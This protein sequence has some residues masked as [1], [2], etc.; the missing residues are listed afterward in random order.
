E[1]ESFLP[2]S[3][4]LPLTPFSGK[5]RVLTLTRPT[6]ETTET[7]IQSLADVQ[8]TLLNQWQVLADLGNPS[9]SLTE[10]E[11][12]VK[13]KI[14]RAFEQYQQV[15]TAAEISRSQAQQ[16]VDVLTL[17]TSHYQIEQSRLNSLLTQ[18]QE[19]ETRL[20]ELG[21]QKAALET[22]T[23]ELLASIR[24][25]I[26]KAEADLAKAKT[27]LL[28]PFADVDDNLQT[29]PQPWQE[30]AHQEAQTAQ[31]FQ[32]QA[33]IQG[34]EAQRYQAI[35][36]NINP[37]RW[38]VVKTERDR[39]GRTKQ[40]WG[41]G[42]NQ[43]LLKQQTQAKWQG[44]VAANNSTILNQ[45]SQ[46]SQI[47]QDNLTDYGEFLAARK[48]SLS[49]EGATL[50]DVTT[51]IQFLQQQ[52][53]EQEKVVNQ[54]TQLTAIAESRRLENQQLVDWHN[55][56]IKRWE[57][58][59]TKRKRSGKTKKVYGWVHYPEHILPRNQAQQLANQ[60]A[61]EKQV[62]QQLTAQAQQQLDGLNEQIRQLQ[63]RQRDW[64]VLKQGIEYEIAASELR[65]QGQIDLLTLHEPVQQQKLETLNLQIQQTETELNQLLQEQLPSQQ[66][67]TDKTQQRLQDT[68]SQW[69][70]SQQAA[71]T[72]QDERQNQLELSGFLLPYRERLTAIRTQ[73]QRLEDERV[74]VQLMIQE[75]TSQLSQTPSESLSQQLSEWQNYLETLNQRLA[76]VTIQQ[77][78]LA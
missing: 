8:E 52:A 61:Q 29:N 53:A 63:E 60:A 76:W 71:A 68:Q 16:W 11:A 39:S 7:A 23:Q 70:T 22:D 47:Q 27:K 77:E 15:I 55:S 18:Q 40:V 59:G 9:L 67:L 5:G 24:H 32:A 4:D 69:Q 51:I 57:V 3:S 49:F 6:S 42:T 25:E 14:N 66:E 1:P 12:E 37:R 72:A 38:Q 31:T 45:L 54:Y 10:L 62:Y 65:R 34:A 73:Q 58:I 50:D 21:T 41:W 13:A 56:R 78:Q 26:A 48:D 46:A 20:T 33:A 35:A 75:L 28:N 64:D 36:A 30:A 44:D 17:A 74:D 19:L 2:N 43:Q